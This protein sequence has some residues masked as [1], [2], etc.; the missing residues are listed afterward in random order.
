MK[1]IKIIGMHIFG[2]IILIVVILDL[3]MGSPNVESK[4]DKDK[5][6]LIPMEISGKDEVEQ[7]YEYDVSKID[8]SGK[9]LIFFTGHQLIHVYADGKEI[10]SVKLGDGV[11]AR[12][13][14]PRWDYVDIPEKTEKIVITLKAVYQSIPMKSFQAYIG[15]A[16]V[17]ILNNLRSSFPSACIDFSI[18]AV[19]IVLIVFWMLERK[20]AGNQRVILYFGFFVF[21][22]GLWCFNET[23]FLTVLTRN[24]CGA[25]FFSFVMLMLIPIPYI[26]YLT[27]FLDSGKK[28]FA[29]L[30]VRLSVINTCV[31]IVL[32]IAGIA[33]VKQTGITEQILLLSAAI[34]HIWTMI[35]YFRQKGMDRILLTNLIGTTGLIFSGLF[36]LW[37]YYT[38]MSKNPVIAHFGLLF[39]VTFLGVAAI[40]ATRKNIEELKSVRM[41]KEIALKDLQTG[42]FNR[43]AYD[44]LLYSEKSFSGMAIVAFDINNLKKCNDMLGH[45]AGDRL[46]C[47]STAL[48]KQYF[49]E[50]GVTYRIGGDQFCTVVKERNTKE[51]LAKI[52]KF[53]KVQSLEENPESISVACGYA[54][55]DP[56]KDKTIEDTRKRADKYLYEDKKI[57]KKQI[58]KKVSV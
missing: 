46:I 31:C 23:V 53:K 44:R 4:D 55:F 37:H 12:T 8:K 39:S 56:E 33:S 41:Y 48:I 24:R 22:V 16:K 36:D 20:N 14:G 57:M 27:T 10:Y 28:F 15:N 45:E 21:F 1:N 58:E 43:N 7:R 29:N 13:T 3:F 34:Y 42:L 5:V 17:E 52:K 9:S 47:N 19:G 11:F 50:I 26:K 6:L 35:A 49:G 2:A 40:S 32:H 25:S 18:S 38:S 51:L 30:I 54:F